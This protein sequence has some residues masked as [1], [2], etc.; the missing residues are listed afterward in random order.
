MASSS[1]S[2]VNV[3]DIEKQFNALSA[4]G[5]LSLHWAD[6]PSLTLSYVC[7]YPLSQLT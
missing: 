3:G 5:S 1:T 6:N 7:L 2:S 4:E